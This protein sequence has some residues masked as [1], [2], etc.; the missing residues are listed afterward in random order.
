MFF[1]HTLRAFASI[2]AVLIFCTNASAQNAGREIVTHADSDYF[3]FDLRTEKDVPLEECKAQ[4][5]TDPSCRAFTYNTS[6]QWCFLKSDFSVLNKFAGAVAGKVVLTSGAPDIG[7]PPVLDFVPP[8]V[9]DGSGLYRSQLLKEVVKDPQTGMLLLSSSGERALQANNGAAA[10]DYFRRA[11]AIDPDDGGL[12]ARLAR[13]ALVAEPQDSA[14]SWRLKQAALS[15]AVNAYQ[16]SRH[17]VSRAGALG[18]LGEALERREIWR[19]AITA[20][21]ESLKLV[22]DPRIRSFHAD[23]KSRKGF[24]VVDNTIDSDSRSPRICVQFSENLVKSGVDYASFV[25]VNGKAAEAID[26]REKEICINGVEHGHRYRIDIRPGLP[27]ALGEVIEKLVKLDIYVRDRAALARFT[28][29]NFVLPGT[30]RHGIPVVTVNTAVVDLELFRV[31]DRALPGLLA[32]SR[33][34]RQLDGYDAERIADSTGSR[35]WSGKLDV[36]VDQNREVVTSFPVDEALPERKPGVYVLTAKPKGDRRDNWDSIAT[37]WFVVS[38]IGLS[39]VSGENGIH[40]S[41][42]S[43]ASAKPISGVE[44]KLVARNNEVL[45]TTNT[46]SEGR[47]HFAAGLARGA[48]GLAPQVLTAGAGANDFVFLDMGRAGFD[49]SDRGVEGRPAP[50]AL[51][52]YAW[53]ERGIYRAGETVHVNALLRDSTAEAVDALPLTFIFSR[54][55]GVEDRR[56]VVNNPSMGGYGVALDLQDNAMRG[57]WTLR[58]HTDPKVAALAEKTFLV[59]DFVPDRI[60]FDM[61]SDKPAIAVGQTAKV[62]VDGRYLYGAPAVGLTLEGEVKIRATNEW[63]LHKGYR[64]G[65]TDEEDGEDRQITLANLPVLDAQGKAEFDVRLDDAPSVSGLL[66]ADVAVRMREGGGRAVER[67]LSIA[68]LPDGPMIGIAPEFDG[69]AVQENSLAAFRIIAVAPDGERQALRGVQWSLV[70]VSRNYQWYRDGNSWKYEPVDYTTQV[71]DGVIDIDAVSP[72]PLSAQVGWGRYRLEV[73]SADPDGPASSIEFYA[74]WY[75][76]PSSTNTPDGLEI[77]LDRESYGAGDVARL[78]VSPRFAGELSVTVGADDVLATH[79]AQVPEEGA[80]IEIPVDADWGAGAYVTATLYRPGDAQASRMP[81][82]AI[83]VKWLKIDPGARDLNVN[84]EVADQISPRRTFDVPITVAGAGAGEKAYVTLAAVDVGILNLT[85]YEAPDPDGWYFGQ[86]RLGLEI[87]DIYGRLIDGSAG[88]LGRIRSGGDGP[89]MGSEGSPPTE[90]LVAFHSGIVEL[91]EDGRA[92]VSFDMP[93]FNGT[94][95]LMAVAWSKSGVGHAEKDVI[96]RDPVVVTASLPRFLAPGD[97]ADLRLEFANTDG[98]AGDYT[99]S[100]ET[101]GPLSV[102]EG[103]R[104]IN[105]AENARDAMTIG[106]SA[107]DIGDGRVNVALEGPGGLRLA[108]AL[109]LPVRPASLPV[110]RKFEIP[111]AANGGS[112][113]IDSGLLDGSLLGGA[114]VAINVGH[115]NALDVPA[116]LM[117]LDRYPYGCAEQT[118]SRALPLLYVSELS[119]A[120]GLEED[121]AIAD[122]IQDAVHRVL[123]YQS[124][125]GGFGL[126]GPTSGDLWL[127][128]Y[129]TDFLTR[130]REQKFSVPEAAM[131][132]ALD[133]LQNTIA[134]NNDIKVNGTAI[135]YSLYVLARNRRASAGDLRYYADTQLSAFKSSMARAHIAASLAL[136]GDNERA[137]RAF[138][139]ALR[140]AS[141]HH[142][143][144]RYRGDYGSSLR[145]NA[146][147]LALAAET[148]PVPASMPEMMELVTAGQSKRRYTSTQE[149]AW[150]LLAARAIEAGSPIAIAVDGAAHT[151]TFT[152]RMSGEDLSE[153]PL[154]VENRGETEIT[155]TI[156]AIA[157]PEQP[158]PAGGNGF[159]IERTY[160]RMDGTAANVSEAQQNDRFVVVI[161]VKE[162]NAWPSRVLVNDLLPAGFEI[163]NP[164]LVSSAELSEFAWL[165]RTQAAHLEFRDDRFIAAFNRAG[166]DAREF[167]FAYVVRA[168]TPGVY[169]H[170]AASVEDMYRPE[171]SARTATGVMAVEAR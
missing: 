157:A 29:D 62:S 139:S 66:S 134:Y 35:V 152:K 79:T 142:K 8:W 99:L 23:L 86:R 78:K 74:G 121:P 54:P 17:T 126:W 28:G 75:V 88:V 160:Y 40:V 77:A 98:P 113:R 38:D 171:F 97:V 72:S 59:E 119:A 150:M 32:D 56:V 13:A 34:L 58:V 47:A 63:E 115:K 111:L 83:G 103:L 100:I 85:R 156:T 76:E 120:A 87:R 48:G 108:Q 42:R 2:L 7:A 84:L 161:K 45:A 166:R 89:G 92:T 137:Q 135:A 96:V 170:P 26:M 18:L 19:P 117:S 145:D 144:N 3:G 138:A 90:K 51:D 140:Q 168:V 37:Q 53:T 30:G 81:M 167:S 130:A 41:A 50:G 22:D 4:C 68:V 11:L 151:G 143:V 71:A 64:F 61:A 159:D 15:A 31:G 164:R 105:L 82:R 155:A 1:G 65:L 91:D 133:N 52:L 16:L 162:K 21:V 127:D 73:E 107:L 80:E 6:A 149:Q 110:A 129:V 131:R 20:Y 128:A 57:A 163:D 67:D 132:Q 44:L 25:T 125:S 101:N 158:L 112:L 70:K 165:P 123:A 118:T 33:F 94:V 9:R 43:L 24:R 147:M 146:A 153:N 55:D 14:N 95:R 39:A 148:Q 114:S 122:R 104:T 10:F 141:G 124:T 12:W 93:Q 102:P 169:A 46:D 106:I 60:E 5:L 69:G 154:V 36:A 136:Y 49:L 27:A 116:L 109:D